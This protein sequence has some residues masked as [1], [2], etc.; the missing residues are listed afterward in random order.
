MEGCHQPAA[1]IGILQQRSAA[2]KSPQGSSRRHWPAGSHEQA[3]GALPGRLRLRLRLQVSRRCVRNAA[4][5][6]Q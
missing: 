2:A 3:K 4:Q 6:V 5:R 1:T